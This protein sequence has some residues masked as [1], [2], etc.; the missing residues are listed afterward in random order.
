M[1]RTLL[2]AA[3]LALAPLAAPAGEITCEIPKKPTI[4][5]APDGGNLIYDTRQPMAALQGKQMDTV[6][7]YGFDGVTI[8]Q[9]YMEGAIAVRPSVKVDAY[10]VA[11]GRG[12]CVY[13]DEIVIEIKID[14][15][16]TI[17]KEVWADPC[18]RRAVTEHELKH[19]TTDRRIVN[20]YGAAMAKRVYE[21]LRER[22]FITGPVRAEDAQ[23]AAEQM[24]Q[25]VFDLVEHEYK[26]MELER[27]EAQQAVDSREEYDRVAAQCPR[28]SPPEGAVRAASGQRR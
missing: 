6:S 20:K 16:I 11:R 17:A 1:R 7:P 9:G 24:Q 10:P 13:Y 19:V 26:K 3:L 15:K 27:A 22:G 25:M 28:W 4:R 2:I 5:V 12:A 8:T 18:M 23:R 14:P 21:R